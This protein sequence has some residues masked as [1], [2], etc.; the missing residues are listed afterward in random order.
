VIKHL[1]SRP[2]VISIETHGKYYVNPFIKQI[3]EWMQKENYT[4][5]YKDRSDTIFIKSG[6]LEPTLGEQIAT[7]LA[8]A[9]IRWKKIKRIFK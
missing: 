1:K 2:K 3:E 5:W 7:F 9:R 6:F 8:L 4:V